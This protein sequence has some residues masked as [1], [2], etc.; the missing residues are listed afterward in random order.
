[1]GI[2]KAQKGNDS[3]FLNVIGVNRYLLICPDK[4]NFG[5]CCAG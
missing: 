4:I 3:R 1:M 5:K 2:R